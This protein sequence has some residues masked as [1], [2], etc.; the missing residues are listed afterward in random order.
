MQTGPKK[1]KK[2][3]KLLSDVST[4]SSHVFCVLDPL[5]L[6]KYYGL[7]ITSTLPN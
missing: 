1:K 5:A 6:K 4:H 7:L 3:K 2:K